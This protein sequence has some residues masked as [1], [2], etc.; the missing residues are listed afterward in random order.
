MI[1]ERSLGGFPLFNGPLDAP[2][3]MRKHLLFQAPQRSVRDAGLVG[4]RPR[5]GVARRHRALASSSRLL[6]EAEPV[7]GDA[8][9]GGFL[10]SQTLPYCLLR[11]RRR[12]FCRLR[13]HRLF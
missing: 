11:V 3:I 1:R 2:P 9:L 12:R 7:V 5:V 6:E 4:G 10:I 13:F 8:V